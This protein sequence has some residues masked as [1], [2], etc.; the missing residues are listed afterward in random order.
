MENDEKCLSLNGGGSRDVRESPHAR[1]PRKKTSGPLL[2]ARATLEKESRGPRALITQSE[3]VVEIL[4]L[5]SSAS[6]GLPAAAE[7]MPLPGPA[8]RVCPCG[9]KGLSLNEP[10][11]DGKKLKRARCSQRANHKHPHNDLAPKHRE[12]ARARLHYRW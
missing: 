5:S 1:S 11:G 8:L 7:C 4:S 3:S 9:R 10:D 6:R 12:I 2:V